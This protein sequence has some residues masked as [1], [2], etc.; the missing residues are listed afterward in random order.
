MTAIFTF[1]VEVPMLGSTVHLIY[2]VCLVMQVFT[3]HPDQSDIRNLKDLSGP[4]FLNQY[5]HRL[6]GLIP[7]RLVS[8]LNRILSHPNLSVMTL[9]HP[10]HDIVIKSIKTER[11]ILRQVAYLIKE[12]DEMLFGYVADVFSFD[13]L[14]R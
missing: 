2:Q 7:L 1:L 13:R 6:H 5:I 3:S 12:I 4:T 14:Q 8:Q 9:L 11:P 10:L